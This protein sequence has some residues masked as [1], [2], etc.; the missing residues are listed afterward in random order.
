M[1]HSNGKVFDWDAWNDEAYT[2]IDHW[3]NKFDRGECV[4]IS[5]A[6]IILPPEVIDTNK[7]CPVIKDVMFARCTQIEVF[8][9]KG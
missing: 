2:R 1:G 8:F 3:R 6:E 5:G 4:S 7:Y 9:R